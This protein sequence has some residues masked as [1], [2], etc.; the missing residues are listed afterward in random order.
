MVS[1]QNL[2]IISPTIPDPTMSAGDYRVFTLTKQ[3]K[4]HFNIF[5]MPLNY[6]Y[7]ICTGLKKSLNFVKICKP[8]SSIT[9]FKNFLQQHEISICIIEKYFSI[10]FE[11][12]KFLP[13]IKV[14][15]IDVHEIGFLKSLALSKLKKINNLKLFKAKELLFYK[16]AKIL[17][18][19]TEKEKN[20]LKEYF[21]NKKIVV[22][23]TCTNVSSST[24]KYF[25]NRNNICYFGYFNHKPNIDAVNYFIENIFGKIKVKIPD[26][27]FYILG[28][29][30]KNIKNTDD[31]ISVDNIKNISKEL[32]KYKV[33]VCPL[34]YG[35]GL[36]KK[37]LDAMSAKTPIVSTSFGT[38][39]IKNVE[40]KY[41]NLSD[42]KFVNE[43]VKLYKN[44]NFWQ[45][46]SDD[47]FNTV[48]KYYSMVSFKQ[49]VNDF[50]KQIKS[51][52]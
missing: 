31:I 18:A 6:K 33:F 47:N 48:K 9:K 11:I 43:I 19:I 40:K 37:V 13:L 26:I 12:C 7:S 49:Y 23:P 10:P 51:H 46:K 25:E 4:K 14:P 5:F 1:K 17:I 8:V 42:K 16:N 36:K 21:P 27:K 45:K 29:G 34:R 22:V 24:K 30:S 35:A 28:Y 50:V 20:I 38:E 41:F 32:S 3:L 15:I 39:G 52:C 44:K 2:L